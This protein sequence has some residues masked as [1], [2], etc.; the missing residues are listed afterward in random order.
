MSWLRE[1]RYKD[2]IMIKRADGSV[3]VATVNDEPSLTQQSFKDQVDVNNI[4]KKYQTTGEW[5]HLTKKQ[6]IYADVSEI[7]DYQESLYKIARAQDAFM[8]LPG[9][10]RQQFG[11]DPA[12]LLAFLQDPANREKAQQMGLI[13]KQDDPGD[14]I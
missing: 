2:K 3:R 10:L 11:N 12:Q 1:I 5:L 6:G 9:D 14:T 8:S 13:Q 7:T 4:V